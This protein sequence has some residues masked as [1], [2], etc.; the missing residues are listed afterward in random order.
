MRR[1]VILNPDLF[2]AGSSRSSRDTKS[3]INR[4]PNKS[5]EEKISD[6]IEYVENSSKCHESRR[7]YSDADPE[8][9]GTSFESKECSL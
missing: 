1:V 3:K 4:F 8:S 5:T 7:Q 2:D 6:F 9:L